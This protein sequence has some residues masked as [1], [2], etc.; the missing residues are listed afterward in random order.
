MS[1]HVCDVCYYLDSEHPERCERG[2]QH[3]P[4]V[5]CRGCPCESWEE[6][7][8]PVPAGRNMLG[9]ATDVGDLVLIDAT[10]SRWGGRYG[11]ISRR[12]NVAAGGAGRRVA[13]EVSLFDEGRKKR[14]TVRVLPS[15]TVP[16]KWPEP[17]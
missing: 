15:S 14:R 4:A 7:H 10:H 6:E 1:G 16:V 9:R 11:R 13:F 5:C 8:K 3:F 2:C 12:V 17:A